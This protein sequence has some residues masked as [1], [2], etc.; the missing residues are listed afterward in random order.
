MDVDPLKAEILPDSRASF[1]ATPKH[2]TFDLGMFWVPIYCASCHREGG[3]VPEENMTFAFWIC[4]DCEPKYGQLTAM[5]MVPDA[6]FWETVKQ[7]QLHHGKQR[8]L[9]AGEMQ[10]TLE[11]ETSPLSTLL[12]Q[13]RSP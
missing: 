12:K 1:I 8:L 5:M 9:T 11:A 3:K 13:G 10:Q 6:V 2:A 7:E 4:Q